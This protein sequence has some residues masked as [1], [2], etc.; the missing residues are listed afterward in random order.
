ML[1]LSGV[2]NTSPFDQH[3]TTKMVK[4]ASLNIACA[5]RDEQLC[6]LWKRL[7]TLCNFIATN[8][9]DHNFDIFCVQEIRPTGT[10]R[11]D[12]GAEL[13]AFDV[14]YLLSEALGKWEFVIHKVNPSFGSFYR[15]TFWDPSKYTCNHNEVIYSKNSREPQFPYMLMVSSFTT[16]GSTTNETEFKVVN[17]HAPMT[18][19]DK[20]EYWRLMHINLCFDM[21]GGADCGE[22]KNADRIVAIGDVNKFEEHLEQ[23]NY[24]FDEETP[25]R[26]VGTETFVSFEHDTKPDTSLWRSCLDSVITHKSHQVAVT[27]VSTTVDN[28]SVPGVPGVP[29]VP[30]V[31]SGTAQ[32][33]PTD[34]FLIVADVNFAETLDD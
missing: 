27:V 20:I 34:H 6:P 17:C 5:G 7:P 9:V 14:A 18:I 1:I 11:D 13:K 31:P 33:R 3:P 26:I 22:I 21:R 10:K 32:L 24:I 12:G 25:D 19:A 16:A 30:S 23:Y 8:K 29:S 2:K 15:A 4:I 28:S